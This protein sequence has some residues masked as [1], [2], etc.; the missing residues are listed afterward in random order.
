MHEQVGGSYFKFGVILL[1]DQTGS[2]VRSL[3]QE[4]LRNP[5]TIVLKI[6]NKWMEGRGL[7]VMWESL[8]KTLR[9]VNLSTLA[10]NIHHQLTCC[11]PPPLKKQKL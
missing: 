3:E 5:E 6:L 4:C 7:P 8:I 9:D 10:D 11:E 1:N 2:L